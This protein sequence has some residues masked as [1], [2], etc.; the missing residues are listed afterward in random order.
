[1]EKIRKAMA[2]NWEDDEDLLMKEG[3]DGDQLGMQEMNNNEM[4]MEDSYSI[5]NRSRL[6][7]YT[8]TTDC[9]CCKCCECCE[10]QKM[11]AVSKDEHCCCC[12][13][14][15]FGIWLIGIYIFII[16]IEMAT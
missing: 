7:Y 1:M 15:V 3:G 8:S 16:T 6:S 4:M 5:G 2:E 14:L 11:R 13:P 12:L 9:C 10:C